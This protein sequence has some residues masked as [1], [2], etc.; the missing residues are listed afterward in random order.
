MDDLF[1]G[2][3]TDGELSFIQ[4]VPL[5]LLGHQVVPGNMELFIFR[6]AGYLD[7]LIPE[8]HVLL[9]VQDL[10]KRRRHISLVIAGYLIDLV[11]KH[12]RIGHARLAHGL[13]DPARHGTHIRLSVA[14]DLR[15]VMDAAQGDTGQLTV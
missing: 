13:G 11:Q 9:S 8:L 5:Q 15:L 3:I 2:L 7:H 12:Q 10:Q 14:A 4:P 1:Q 6:I